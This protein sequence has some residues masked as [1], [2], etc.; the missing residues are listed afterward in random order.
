MKSF[1]YTIL[2]LVPLQGILLGQTGIQALE[3]L[4]VLIQAQYVALA[5]AALTDLL[6]A[7]NYQ[8]S[9]DMS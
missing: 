9:P 2:H 1:V 4:C 5:I 7:A 8:F 6:Q 3:V